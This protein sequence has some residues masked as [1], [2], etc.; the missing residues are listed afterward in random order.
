VNVGLSVDEI[1]QD[2]RSQVAVV[3]PR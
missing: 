1:V 2:I 3:L